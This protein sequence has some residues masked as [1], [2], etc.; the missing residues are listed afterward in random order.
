MTKIFKESI[1]SI[2]KIKNI[3]FFVM[4]LTLFS[5]ALGFYLSD[6]QLPVIINLKATILNQIKNFGPLR[7]IMDALLKK[8]VIYAILYTF[9]FN[10]GSGAF[11]SV[12]LSGIIFPLP[13]LIMFERGV[14]IGLLYGDLGGSWQYY[15]VF[16][17][18]LILEF[19]AYILAS[20]AGINIG[21]S[22]FTPKRFGTKSSWQAFGRSWIEAG[23]ILV[24]V[25]II[26]FVAA[27]WEIGGMYLLIK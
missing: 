25:A 12:I 19:G 6:S 3:V 9:A 17:G 1:R 4:F 22:F 7:E 15:L 24:I 10:F 20:A 14:F 13:A 8:N 26:L 27:I 18:T 11:L 5:L 21:L 2:K 23:K 16:F